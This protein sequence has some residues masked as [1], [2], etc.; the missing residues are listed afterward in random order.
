MLP[1][2]VAHAARK[3]RVAID[4]EHLL[5]LRERGVVVAQLVVHQAQVVETG[6]LELLVAH[7]A[8]HGRRAPEPR[9]RLVVVAEV[10]GQQAEHVERLALC[11]AIAC[12]AP[13]RAHGR[14]TRALLE[15]AE[16]PVTLT[17]VMERGRLVAPVF[18]ASKRLGQPFKLWEGLAR[19][20]PV[21][22]GPPRPRS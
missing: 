3:I 12:R 4:P 16:P 7:L 14:G 2:R 11:Q 8:R 19:R 10:P 5:V 15:L 6:A 1:E 17:D 21:D 22:T 13:A 18:S 20:R 9:H